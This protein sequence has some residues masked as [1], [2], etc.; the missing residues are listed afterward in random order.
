MSDFVST[1]PG[2]SNEF[3]RIS[4]WPLVKAHADCSVDVLNALWLRL[5]FGESCPLLRVN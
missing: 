2:S 3:S 5:A 1:T 4:I